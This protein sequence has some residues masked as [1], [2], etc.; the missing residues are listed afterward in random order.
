MVEMI[1]CIVKFFIDMTVFSVLPGLICLVII[2]L[3]Y[4]LVR[5]VGPLIS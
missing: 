4:S 3:A 1:I 2:L 5:G